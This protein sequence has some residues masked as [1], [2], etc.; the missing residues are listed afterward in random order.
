M[1]RTQGPEP[2]P[3]A[4]TRGI[5]VRPPVLVD[6]SL[7]DWEEAIRLVALLALAMQADADSAA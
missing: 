2:A 7:E 4:S 3:A 1:P 6:M 5:T